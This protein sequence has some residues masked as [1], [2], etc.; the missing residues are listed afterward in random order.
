[1]KRDRRRRYR[2]RA[3]VCLFVAAASGLVAGAVVIEP[4]G[5]VPKAPDLD[6]RRA[7]IGER[8]FYDVRV[9]RDG[10][11]ACATCHPLERGG[12]DGLPVAVRHDGTLH[13]RNTPTIFNVSLNATFNWDGV[14]NTLESHTDRIVPG[15]MNITWPELIARLRVDRA[16]ASAFAAAYAEGP[17][18]ANVLDAVATFERSLLTPNSRFDRFLLGE[19]D[20]LTTREQDGYL[21]FKS[22]GCASCHQGINVGGN[23]YQRFGVFESMPPGRALVN[24]A[25]RFLVTK[26]P[27]DKNVFRVP[28]LRNVAITAPYFHDGNAP[29]LKVAVDTMGKV[30][31]GR[32]LTP[33]DIGLIVEF[34]GTL[35]GEYRGRP[36][37]ARPEGR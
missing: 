15:L 6:P 22:H 10:N 28:S 4:I 3:F 20:A 31:L 24:D 27:R 18:H 26:V 36:F 8:L 12:M 9:S 23:L 34:L 13:I 32:S 17:T 7:A 19:R 2:L 37:T 30:Q 1:M 33:N 16:Y 11:Q 14:V 25:G 5:P 29:T 21:L 35:T